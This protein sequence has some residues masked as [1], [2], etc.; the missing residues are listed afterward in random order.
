[1]KRFLILAIALM[2]A[3]CVVAGCAREAKIYYDP[4]E[5]ISVRIN[6]DFIIATSS[7]PS[8]GYIWREKYDENMLEL[9][10]ST[11]EVSEAVKRGEAEIGLEQHFRFK[12]LKKGNTEIGIELVGPDLKWVIERKVFNVKID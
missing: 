8:T 3:V 1:M 12:A 11:F 4:E 7:S 2:L 9:L 10:K 6:R 5:M